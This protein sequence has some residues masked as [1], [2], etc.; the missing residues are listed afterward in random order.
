MNNVEGKYLTFSLKNETY[1][2]P[3]RVVKEINAMMSITEVPNTP[4]YVKGVINL[5]GKII[6]IIDLRLKLDMLPK[7]YTERTCIVVVEIQ[8]EKNKKKLGIVVDHVAEVIEIKTSELEDF[9]DDNQISES[10]YIS[11]IAKIK[12]KI[13]ILLDIF[14]IVTS[15]EIHKNE[16]V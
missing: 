2:I 3:I 14:K 1:G 5:R 11:G 15:N 10:Y 12:D 7:D 6:S 16:E 13:I 4:N 8:N 9:E